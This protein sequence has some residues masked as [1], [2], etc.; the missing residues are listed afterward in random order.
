MKS[1]HTGR[2]GVSVLLAVAVVALGWA[3]FGSSH[4]ALAHPIGTATGD[5]IAESA[6][7]GFQ[8]TTNEYQNLPTQTTINVTFTNDDSTG[9]TH[10]FT[11]VNYSGYVI[12]QNPPAGKSLTDLLSSPGTLISLTAAQG[13]TVQGEFTSPATG[14]YEFVCSI[15]GHFGQG[16]Y[17]FIAFGEALPSNLTFGKGVSGPG[18]AVFIIVGTIVALTVLALVLGF[19]VG[20]RHGSVHEMPPERLGYPEPPTGGAQSPPAAPGAGR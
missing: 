1:R 12:K 17:G 16:M 19:V 11:I 7:A 10:T 13:Q 5:A 3:G 20:R 4:V 18:L 9:N 2:R 14:W 6:V 15:S 8:F